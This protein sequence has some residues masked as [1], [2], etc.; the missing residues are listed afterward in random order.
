MPG[1]SAGVHRLYPCEDPRWAG[2][3]PADLR[4]PGGDPGHLVF[5]GGPIALAVAELLAVNAVFATSASAPCSCTTTSE[6]RAPPGGRARRGRVLARSS[7]Y[8]SAHLEAVHAGVAD[9]GQAVG[10]GKPGAVSD[11]ALEPDRGD[12]APCQH[13][14][15]VDGTV[16]GDRGQEAAVVGDRAGED[17]RARRGQLAD[18]RPVA[19]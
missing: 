17:A 18:H 12:P 4:G 11:R 7:R 1:V 10:P 6:I 19:D 16:V 14:P 13:A 9:D 3:Q 2:R 5:S 8:R 15:H